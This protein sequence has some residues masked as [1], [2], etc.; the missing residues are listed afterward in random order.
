M[1]NIIIV[2]LLL[3]DVF[4]AFKWYSVNEEKSR[5]AAAVSDTKDAIED[6]GGVEQLAANGEVARALEIALAKE[7]AQKAKDRQLVAK[8]QAEIDKATAERD[9]LSGKIADFDAKVEARRAARARAAGTRQE[10]LDALRAGALGRPLGEGEAESA[11]YVGTRNGI[12]YFLDGVGGWYA[13]KSLEGWSEPAM[14]N[15]AKRDE[16]DQLKRDRLAELLARQGE[17]NALTPAE[18][19]ELA[20]LQKREKGFELRQL[21]LEEHPDKIRN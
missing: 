20:K 21:E 6:L 5:L 11:R 15:V 4:L 8:L 3:A 17:G 16:A 12:Y 9:E 10:S 2:V 19:E 14:A 7:K 18:A 1:K 13:R